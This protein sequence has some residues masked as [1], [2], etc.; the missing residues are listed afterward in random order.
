MS[1]DAHPQIGDVWYRVDGSPESEYAYAEYELVWEEWTVVK[2]TR[3]GAWFSCL[4]W[5][6]KTRD[7]NRFASAEGSRWL[8]R[9]KR[10]ALR[11][12]VARKVR[13]LAIL[14]HQRDGAEKTLAV[15]KA[16]LQA[17]AVPA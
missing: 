15:A 10:D 1:K 7:K 12:L 2:V 17:E 4:T 6:Y 14:E 11:G 13:H 3:T 8:R 16:A 9:T 5:P